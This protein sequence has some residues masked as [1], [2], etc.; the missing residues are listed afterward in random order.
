V[1]WYND[2]QNETSVAKNHRN[3]L[4]HVNNVGTR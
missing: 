2:S 4:F 1:G 3:L